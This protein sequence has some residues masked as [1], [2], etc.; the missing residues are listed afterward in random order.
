MPTQ[1]PLQVPAGLR[2]LVRDNF[3]ANMR[4]RG[5]DSSQPYL[6]QVGGV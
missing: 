2:K 4:L 6:D 1:L 5:G 3:K